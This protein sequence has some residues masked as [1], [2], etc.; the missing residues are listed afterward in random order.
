VNPRASSRLILLTTKSHRLG[1]GW[2]NKCRVGYQGLSL[3][4]NNHRQSGA[5]G[6]MSQVGSPIAPARCATEVSTVINTS[7]FSMIAAVSA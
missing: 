6:N 5:K 1:F 4:F 2:R 7:R 3:R